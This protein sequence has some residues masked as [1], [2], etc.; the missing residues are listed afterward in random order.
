LS[1]GLS[2]E[3]ARRRFF[4]FSGF[5]VFIAL[6]LVFALALRFWEPALIGAGMLVFLTSWL[7]GLYVLGW[8]DSRP[9]FPL[10]YLLSIS[11]SQQALGELA[12]AVLISAAMMMLWQNAFGVALGV[13]LLA[14][15][16]ASVGFWLLK[17]KGRLG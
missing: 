7:R 5:A 14:I 1:V 2:K 4:V 3:Q 6:D 17:G 12:G 10:R 15:N 13:A 8:P 16:T 11:R 9:G